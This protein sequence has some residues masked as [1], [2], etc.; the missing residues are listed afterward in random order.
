VQQTNQEPEEEEDRYDEVI[1]QK[2]TWYKTIE[3]PN[4]LQHFVEGTLGV[5]QEIWETLGTRRITFLNKQKRITN[6]QTE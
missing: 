2:L 1:T 4:A 6:I 3:H 5:P